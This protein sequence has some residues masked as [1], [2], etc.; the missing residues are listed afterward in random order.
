MLVDGNN[1]SE[2][3]SSSSHVEE[4][5]YNPVN[6]IVVLDE[7]ATEAASEIVI[8]PHVPADE[9]L[10]LDEEKVD[11]RTGETVPEEWYPDLGGGGN[12]IGE[13][14]QGGG[15]NPCPDGRK[16]V[17]VDDDGE[18]VVENIP[19]KKKTYLRDSGKN[20]YKERFDVGNKQRLLE[21]SSTFLL[22]TL[23]GLLVS[24][25][26]HDLFIT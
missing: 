8:I 20:A 17:L 16:L 9:Y 3:S 6:D 14:G 18:T 22:W 21:V 2:S 4:E 19:Q 12:G 1:T 13:T 24:N 26:S 7:N 10:E 23:L 25:P 15:N 5:E 11:E